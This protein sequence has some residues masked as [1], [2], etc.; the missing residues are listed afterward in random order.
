MPRGF[1]GGIFTTSKSPAA[2][3]R[4]GAGV[5]QALQVLISLPGFL[6]RL[7]ITAQTVVLLQLAGLLLPGA[8]ILCDP[9][10]AGQ[11]LALSAAMALVSKICCSADA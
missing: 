4:S 3:N 6:A 8:C 11:G 2:C 9:E 7:L 1:G 10:L 5:R